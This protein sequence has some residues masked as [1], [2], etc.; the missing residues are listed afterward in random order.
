LPRLR[1]PARPPRLLK[2]ITTTA[3]QQLQ[4]QLQPIQ[5]QTM[6]L[7]VPRPRCLRMHIRAHTRTAGATSRFP[8]VR[9]RFRRHPPPDPT[10]STAT[11]AADLPEAATT[12]GSHRIIDRWCHCRR[13]FRLLPS[14]CSIPKRRSRHPRPSIASSNTITNML[15]NRPTNTGSFIRPIMVAVVVSIT[16]SN[17]TTTNLF[18]H[19]RHRISETT[20]GFNNSSIN[21]AT[22]NPLSRTEK[23]QEKMVIA[24]LSDNIKPNTINNNINI[25]TVILW[26][27]PPTGSNPSTIA[28]LLLGKTRII[29]IIHFR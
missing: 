2:T 11:L 19:H 17:I 3:R 16:G 1:Y 4:L 5:M 29:I 8:S 25:N 15:P 6:L 13:L 12:G 21:T 18:R 27:F 7:P 10:A 9:S 23:R 26:F 20:G 28:T 24:Q 22:S 14:I